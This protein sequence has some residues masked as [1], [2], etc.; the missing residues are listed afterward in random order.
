MKIE[1]HTEDGQVL[2]AG[3]CSLPQIGETVK[4]KQGAQFTIEDLGR[5]YKNYPYRMY[6]VKPNK[7]PEHQTPMATLN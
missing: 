3:V 5:E 6:K 7:T 4:T 1:L 2:H